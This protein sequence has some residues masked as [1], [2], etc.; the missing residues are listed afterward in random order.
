MRTTV[1]AMIV[2]AVALLPG[3]AGAESREI[4]VFFTEWSARIDQPADDIIRQAAERASDVGA[5]MVTVTGLADNTASTRAASLLS[6]TR[7][8]VVVD[9]LV[10]DG[11]N[12]DRIR[13]AANGGTGFVQS[14]LES[15]RVTIDI[16]MD[17]MIAALPGQVKLALPARVVPAAP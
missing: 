9:R 7:A 8:Q 5:G 2:A 12:P 3:V 15:H 11:I 4:V 10:E 16:S 6:A 1:R 17:A 14:P 13:L